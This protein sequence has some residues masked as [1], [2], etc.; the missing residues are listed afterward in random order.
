MCVYVNMTSCLFWTH[1]GSYC[2]KTSVWAKHNLT[3][4]STLQ[5]FDSVDGGH[6]LP[7]H[8]DKLTDAEEMLFQS[9]KTRFSRQNLRPSANTAGNEVCLCGQNMR[10]LFRQRYGGVALLTEA[11]F[12]H[13]VALRLT[14]Q[15]KNMKRNLGVVQSYVS[16]GYIQTS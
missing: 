12:C 8:G 6:F 14:V 10:R 1:S 4:L 9:K 2:E 7:K 11:S 13:S 5:T 15:A 16:S 3:V